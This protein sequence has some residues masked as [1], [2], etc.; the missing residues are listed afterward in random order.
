MKNLNVKRITCSGANEY[1]S[2][3]GLVELMKDYPS[4]ELGIQVSERKASVG[5]TRYFW[6]KTLIKNVSHLKVNMALHINENWVEDFCDGNIAPELLEFIDTGMFKRIQ[7]NFKVGSGKTPDIDKLLQVMQK[8]SQIR[9]ILSY[10]ESNAGLIKEIYRRNA[11]FDILCDESYGTGVTPKKWSDIIFSDRFQGY[12]GGLSP[13][14]IQE[15]LVEISSAISADT[16]DIFVD[17]QGKLENEMG[18]F[19]I[20]KAERFVQNI[21]NS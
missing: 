20:E 6:I 19:C 7:L 15:K 3:N 18:K 16:V 11:M 4:L 21:L 12:S 14:N 5:T 17:A 10:C 13:E 8:F 1:T 9:F 2:I